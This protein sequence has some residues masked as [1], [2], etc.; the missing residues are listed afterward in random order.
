MNENAVIFDLDG[1]LVDSIEDIAISMN[2]VLK[3]KNYKQHQINEYK[4]F[5]GNGA[6]TLVEK[7]SPQETSKEEQEELLE[8]FKE[9]YKEKIDTTTKVYE[10]I[11]E[12]LEKLEKNSYKK[13]I[14]SN[15][16][17]NFT[18]T[19]VEKFFK[20]YDFINISGQKA[21]LP[22]KPAPDAALNIAKQLETHPAN[23]YFVGDTKVDMQTAKNSG[24]KA[25]GVLWGFRD[26]KELRENGADFIV[27]NAQELFEILE[28]DPYVPIACHFYDQL[29]SAAV[30]R[31]LNKIT[32]IQNNKELTIE[33]KLIDFKIIEKVEYAITANKQKIRLD[34]IIDFNGLKQKDFNS[35]NL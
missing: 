9:I 31:T 18:K 34:K 12:L 24:M 1:T 8:R 17:H 6:K 26:E 4:Y 27:K 15:K 7:A 20:D 30:K 28:K 19:C 21:E 14:L 2:E 3:E 16:P 33:D 13:A 29:E 11:Y 35:C 5:I 22:K 25:I 10:G 32:Y 23:I